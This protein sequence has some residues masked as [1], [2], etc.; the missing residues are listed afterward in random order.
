MTKGGRS[1]NELAKTLFNVS[2]TGPGNR[3][4]STGLRASVTGFELVAGKTEA[5]IYSPFVPPQ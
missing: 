1:V 3:A 2:T 4:G 5:P